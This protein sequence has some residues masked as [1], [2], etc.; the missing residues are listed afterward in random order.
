MDR[1]RELA[2]APRSSVAAAL[3]AVVLSVLVTSMSVQAQTDRPKK[4]RELFEQKDL[5]DKYSP[6]LVDKILRIDNEEAEL[7]VVRGRARLMHARADVFR[8]HIADPQIADVQQFSS[9]EISVLGLERGTTS[10]TLW[11]DGEEFPITVRVDVV[12]DPELDNR[13]E[14]DY[15]QLEAQLNEMFPNSHIRLVPVA[16]K[17]VVM[18]QARDAKEAS[19][20]I[21]IV[22][23]GGNNGFN[24][25]SGNNGNGNGQGGGT[26]NNGGFGGG[27]RGYGRGRIIGPAASFPGDEETRSALVVDMLQIPGEHTVALRVKIAELNRSSL[28][29]IGT[30]FF[31]TFGPGG[32]HF[33]ETLLS[34]D[35]GNVNM[36]FNFDPRELNFTLRALASNGTLR[37]LAEPT[38]VTLSGYWASFLAGG[39]FAVPTTVG[40]DG[41]QAVSTQFKGFGVNL[42]FMPTVLDK[43]RVRLIIAPEFSELNSNNAVGG[44]PGLTTRNAYTTVELRA[45]QTYAIAGLIQDTTFNENNRIPYLGDIPFFGTLFSARHSTHNERELIVLVTPEIV[46]PMEWDE[47][48]PLPGYDV[49]EPTDHQTYLIGRTEG[50][51]NSP[52]RSTVWPINW[53]RIRDYLRAEQQY[54]AGPSGHSMPEYSGENMGNWGPGTYGPAPTYGSPSSEMGAGLDPYY[55]DRSAAPARP[56]Q[57]SRLANQPNSS[58]PTSRAPSRY[59]QPPAQPPADKFSPTATRVADLPAPE[60]YSPVS[61]GRT[62]PTPSVPAPPYATPGTSAREW[63]PQAGPVGPNQYRY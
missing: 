56:T 48:P 45:G 54:V 35:N 8:T 46:A 12:R 25:D 33:V 4:S 21:S 9:R 26:S 18:G 55:S 15:S 32:R 37:I 1:I 63:Q 11:F 51:A 13:R 61:R 59:A 52:W 19:E 29:D 53:T 49:T 3:A 22:T 39:Q 31:A 17:V 43:D 62:Y 60:K 40:I 24:N 41:A 44:V 38:L 5:G 36:S 23:S 10:L 34:G 2:R 14:R 20:I 57:S 47:V 7:K 27:N 30:D 6:K 58:A 28:R 42:G 16:D 50:H